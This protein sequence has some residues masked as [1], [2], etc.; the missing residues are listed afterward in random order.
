MERTVT[1]ETYGI[2]A[3]WF[4]RK[5][6]PQ[7]RAIIGLK[8]TAIEEAI[9]KGELPAPAFVTPSGRAVGWQGSQLIGYVRER[10]ERAAVEQEAR[11]A[12]RLAARKVTRSKP[13]K[14]N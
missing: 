2:V 9:A 3:A 1:D 12:A 6:D 13:K 4:Y 8:S 7:T 11:K 5:S 10:M 14:K